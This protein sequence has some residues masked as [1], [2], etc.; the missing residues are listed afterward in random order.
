MKW[1]AVIVLRKNYGGMTNTSHTNNVK[2]YAF[3]PLNKPTIDKFKD[4]DLDDVEFEEKRN[5]S[6]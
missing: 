5:Q 1:P 4:L 2:T 3:V 6:K